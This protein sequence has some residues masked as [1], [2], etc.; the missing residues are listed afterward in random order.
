[1]APRQSEESVEMLATETAKEHHPQFPFPRP[2][3]HAAAAVDLL[4]CLVRHLA[5]L[6]AWDD[7]ANHSDQADVEDPEE[8]LTWSRPEE[9][10]VLAKAWDGPVDQVAKKVVGS[11]GSTSTGIGLIAG[12]SEKE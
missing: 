8:D 2:V 6:A 10:E 11:I 3:C 1:M 9:L 4:D 12:A 7:L 5:A